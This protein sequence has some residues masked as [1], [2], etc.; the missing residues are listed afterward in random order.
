MRVTPPKDLYLDLKIYDKNRSELVNKYSENKGAIVTGSIQALVTDTFYI[1]VAPK[2]GSEQNQA[3]QYSLDV[4]GAAPNEEKSGV[5]NLEERANGRPLPDSS[6]PQASSFFLASI[7]K[8]LKF[9]LLIVATVLII[10]VVTVVL[11]LGKSDKK[12]AL[13][14][15]SP[16]ETEKVKGEK[17]KMNEPEFIYCSKCGAKN[18]ADAHFC[19]KCGK[20]LA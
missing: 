12:K 8:N 18:P 7:G 15:E 9:V 11:L 13:E 19:S 3:S 2:Y 1:A 14:E 10:I 4:S 16:V 6:L 17:K 5:A 20:K